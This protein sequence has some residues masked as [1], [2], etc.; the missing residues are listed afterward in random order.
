MNSEVREIFIEKKALLTGHFLLSSGLHSDHYF[1][2]AKVLQYPEVA[3]KLGQELASHFKKTPIDVVIGPALGGILVS[4]EVARALGVRSIFVERVD[5]IFKL[6]R[7]FEVGPK[8]KILVVED[9]LTTGKSTQEVID[10]LK[11][12][13][14]EIQAVGCLVDRSFGDLDFGVPLKSLLKLDIKTY[15][16]SACPMCQKGTP[17]KKPGSRKL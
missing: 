6:R 4:F 16:P 5:G 11:E 1:Q 3:T 10:V 2:A 13:E 8:E 12:T 9:V 15:E 14:G 7:G 17:A